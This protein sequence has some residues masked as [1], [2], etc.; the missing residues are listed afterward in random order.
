MLRRFWSRDTPAT[1]RPAPDVPDRVSI[2][3]TVGTELPFDRL[4]RVVDEWAGARGRSADV[5][6]QTGES[7]YTPEHIASAPSLDATT[8]RRLFDHADLIVAHAGMG[9]ILGA[10]ERARPLVVVPRRAEFGEHRNDH[11]LATTAQL[12]RLGLINTVLDEH[13]LSAHLDDPASVPRHGP[14]AASADPALLATIRDAI[15]R[16]G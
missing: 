1:D 16:T 4:I 11:Q 7:T 10:L 9:T 2:F 15:H 8:F 12:G 13:E 6:A 5:F 3:V 14:I